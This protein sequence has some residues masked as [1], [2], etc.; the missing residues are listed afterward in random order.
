MICASHLQ[1]LFLLTVHSFSIS[2]YKECNQF[3][4]SID[5]LV[6]SMCKA[7]SCVVEKVYFL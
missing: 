3:D 1:V 4:F 7:I 5:H 6:M 2:G